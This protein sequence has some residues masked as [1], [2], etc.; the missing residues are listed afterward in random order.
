[1]SVAPF[2]WSSISTVVAFGD[3]YSKSGF[4]VHLSTPSITNPFGVRPGE[5]PYGRTSCAGPNWIYQLTQKYSKSPILV[6]NFAS[7]G[8][9][10]DDRLIKSANSWSRSF[11]NQ[12]IDFEGISFKPESTLF[13]IEFG[14]NDVTIG[15]SKLDNLISQLD[16]YFKHGTSHELRI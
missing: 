1:M 3:S 13:T 2:S 7:G 10:V 11:T 12:M 8:A 6:Y 9:T 5:P 16:I 14:I 4:D 15:R